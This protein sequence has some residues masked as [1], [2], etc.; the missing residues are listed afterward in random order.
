MVNV[1]KQ[2]VNNK[3]GGL[4]HKISTI[5]V[6]KQAGVSNL[7]AQAVPSHCNLKQNVT[8]LDAL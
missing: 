7:Y 4:K 3:A 8:V 1:R 2:S 6:A 5:D